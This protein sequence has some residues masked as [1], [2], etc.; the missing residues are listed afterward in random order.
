MKRMIAKTPLLV[1]LAA[2][3]DSSNVGN[4]SSNLFANFTENSLLEN[5]S[6]SSF[7]S[8]LSPL[9]Q[10]GP[11]D[12]YIEQ[13]PV[14]GYPGPLFYALH[15]L[16]LI[17]LSTSVLVSVILILYLCFWSP[18]N[19]S[20]AK[21]QRTVSTSVTTGGTNSSKFQLTN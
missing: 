19:P 8:T 16:A 20:E 7:A 18:T 4:E 14:F 6:N 3:V 9:L 1:L 21:G 15:S 13:M 2:I 10:L 5:L 11:F 12:R 17:S